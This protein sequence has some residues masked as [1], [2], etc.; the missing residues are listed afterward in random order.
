MFSQNESLLPSTFPQGGRNFSTSRS[1]SLFATPPSAPQTGVGR[2]AEG[3]GGGVR[4]W[5]QDRTGA[6]SLE[7]I[8]FPLLMYGQTTK[9]TDWQ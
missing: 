4:G 8:T 9:D 7:I 3:R 6:F 2:D 1:D 5:R